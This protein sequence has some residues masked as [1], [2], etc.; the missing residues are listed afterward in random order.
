MYYVG[1]KTYDDDI[2]IIK[3]ESTL[4]KAKEAMDEIKTG[5][6]LVGM[7]YHGLGIWVQIE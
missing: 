4:E 3:S 2:S 7:D 5:Y 6:M 1:Q